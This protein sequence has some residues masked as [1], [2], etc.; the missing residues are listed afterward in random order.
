MSEAPAPAAVAT[1]LGVVSAVSLPAAGELSSTPGS[2][3]TGGGVTTP[4][5]LGL[6]GGGVTTTGGLALC[7]GRLSVKV[8]AALRPRLPRAS[9]C[10]ALAV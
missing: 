5:K 4:G 2:G 10:S 9:Y 1:N 8:D 7:G 3:I 6:A